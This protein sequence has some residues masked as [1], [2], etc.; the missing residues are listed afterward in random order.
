MTVQP[1]SIKTTVT[2]TGGPISGG[3]GGP[4][5]S[6]SD[7]TGMETTAS[8][9]AAPAASWTA[10]PSGDRT[11]AP[12]ERVLRSVAP[13]SSPSNGN[14]AGE[15]HLPILGTAPDMA[16]TTTPTSTP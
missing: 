2:P 1:V 4:Y 6:T 9:G 12:R 13:T 11:E 14:E 8:P 10:S 3:R 16:T 5:S 15:G 7:A